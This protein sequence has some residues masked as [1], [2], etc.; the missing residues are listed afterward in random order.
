MQLQ[1]TYPPKPLT[2]HIGDL[3]KFD[4]A[5]WFAQIKYD[6]HRA[7][8][9]LDDRG[10][11]VHSRQN[12]PLGVSEAIR[13]A[14]KKMGIPDGTM[15]D[16]EWNAR[17]ASKDEGLFVF[18]AL[19]WGGEWIGS[20]PVEARYERIRSLNFN[21]PIHLVANVQAG[22]TDLMKA[23][24]GKNATEG[25]VLKRRGFTIPRLL[26]D[27]KDIPDMVKIKWRDGPD[28]STIT[29]AVRQSDGALVAV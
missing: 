20:E 28:G 27:S 3:A 2:M 22:F 26:R 13:D 21:G 16:S 8:P 15:L 4:A 29:A 5:R 12:K 24:I 6:G 18:D 10:L 11:L 1:W 7:H 17:R 14:L 23:I 9:I 19:W 25:I